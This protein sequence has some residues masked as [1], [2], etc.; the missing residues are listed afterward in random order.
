MA[1]GFGSNARGQKRAAAAQA[2]LAALEGQAM[3]IPAGGVGGNLTKIEGLVSEIVQIQRA[4]A[5]A[6]GVSVVDASQTSIA[7]SGGPTYVAAKKFAPS[8][9]TTAQLTSSK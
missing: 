5:A 3:A 7:N 2:E 8:D 4:T 1:K 6:A 9:G